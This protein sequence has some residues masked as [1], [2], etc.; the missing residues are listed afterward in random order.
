MSA[1]MERKAKG[2]MRALKKQSRHKRKRKDGL[3][4]DDDSE[5]PDCGFIPT[6][7]QLAAVSIGQNVM[8]LKKKKVKI[9]HSNTQTALTMDRMPTT[10]FSKCKLFQRDFWSGPVGED[11]VSDDLKA[12]R[13][14][15]GILPKGKLT[16]CPPPVLEIASPYLPKEFPVIFSNLNLTK[17]S[18]VQMQCWPT[19]MCGANVLCIA[20]TGS[21]KTLAYSLPMIPHIDVQIKKDPLAN[22]GT[23]A[24]LALVLVPTRELA[25]QVAAVLKALKRCCGIRSLAIYGGQDKDQQLQQL[26][27]FG[28][29]HILV[30]TPGRLLDLIASKHISLHA[31]TYLVLDEADRMLSLGFEKQLDMIASQIRPD[32]QSMLFSATFPGKLRESI[33]K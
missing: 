4:S 16:L 25:I 9:E 7:S 23:P 24:P 21:G 14:T 12:I 26:T 15:L 28:R 19:I 22:P 32:R 17:P 13:K 6:P 1:K 29:T 33:D 11:P 27:Q 18:P 20:P 2:Q 5:S 8:S 31:V 3:D 30:A 10:N